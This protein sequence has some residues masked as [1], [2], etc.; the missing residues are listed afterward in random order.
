MFC[1]LREAHRDEEVQVLVKR[2][3]EGAGVFL[4][5]FLAVH[6]LIDGTADTDRIGDLQSRLAVIP[7]DLESYFEQV[8]LNIDDKI[9]EIGGTHFP[10]Y[11]SRRGRTTLMC[12]WFVQS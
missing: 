8:L 6:S 5:V 11:A 2:I 1:K 9:T 7:T 10:D 12:Y 3:A 4:W